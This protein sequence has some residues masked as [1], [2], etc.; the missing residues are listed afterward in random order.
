MSEMD[1]R[2][3]RDIEKDLRDIAGRLDRLCAI[4]SS[5]SNKHNNGGKHDDEC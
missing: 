3:L 4:M 2:L 5:K 1:T